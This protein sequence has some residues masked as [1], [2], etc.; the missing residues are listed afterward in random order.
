MAWAKSII[1]LMEG[2]CESVCMC[3]SV[4]VGVSRCVYVS[5]SVSVSVQC[6]C[7]CSVEGTCLYAVV[8]TKT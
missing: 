5:V 7:L 4:C 6:L 1:S 3:E 2:L 8:F